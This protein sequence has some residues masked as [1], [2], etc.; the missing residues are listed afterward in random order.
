M[1]ILRP[2]RSADHA[3]I[4]ALTR[5]AFG[6]E[7]EVA[8][9]DGVHAGGDALVERVALENGE[10]VG[11]IL[12]SRMR[13]APEAFL[14]GLAPVS[15]A[16]DRQGRGLGSALVRAGLDAC[17]RLGARGAVVLGRPDYYARFGFSA[18]AAATL[19]CRFAGV[20]AFMALP[21]VHNGLDGVEGV[22][23]PPAFD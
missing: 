1:V 13:C 18:A 7:S 15:V 20:P 8:I 17:K 4:R 19:E 21:L 5:A 22:A 11:H 3:L 16:P 12:F 2:A 9:I 23:Y 6:G 10:V 14:V